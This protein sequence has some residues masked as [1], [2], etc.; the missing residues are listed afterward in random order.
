LCCS[1][2]LEGR[3]D[4]VEIDDLKLW[5]G[6]GKKARTFAKIL[7]ADGHDAIDEDNKRDDR[8]WLVADNGDDFNLRPELEGRRI[9]FWFEQT[10]LKEENL[11]G[12][13]EDVTFTDSVILDAETEAGITILNG[14]EK[15]AESDDSSS[16]FNESDG[17][18]DA[19]DDESA[20]SEDLPDDVDELVDMFARTGQDNRDSIENDR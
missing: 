3:D 19:S 10:T 20:D 16:D 13:D 17:S 1:V 7:S 9:M 18:D 4:P 12:Q 8:N 15:G 14:D 2:R 6:N 5:L 11:E